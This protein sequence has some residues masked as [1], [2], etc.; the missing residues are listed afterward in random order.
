V[1]SIS[2]WLAVVLVVTTDIGHTF[3]KCVFYF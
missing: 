3:L 2:C 1:V